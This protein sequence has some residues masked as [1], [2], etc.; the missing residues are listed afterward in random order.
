M[1]PDGRRDFKVPSTPKIGSE[2]A[3]SGITALDQALRRSC[4]SVAA[5]TRCSRE[6]PEP[7]SSTSS[8]ASMRFARS[9]SRTRR[10]LAAV[11]PGIPRSAESARKTWRAMTLLE[12]L[13]MSRSTF[14][15]GSDS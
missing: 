13:F 14:A 5:L 11:S 2:A 3:S 7:L 6:S 4:A 12:Y 9:Q 10:S 8:G 15:S 1:A